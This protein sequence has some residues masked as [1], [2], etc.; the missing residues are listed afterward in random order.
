MFF[1]G[2][3]PILGLE[4]Q[5]AGTLDSRTLEIP[6]FASDEIYSFQG[7]TYLDIICQHFCSDLEG[8]FSFPIF[9]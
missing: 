6:V 7:S 9:L 5:H 8:S 2:K 1:P 3:H 4:L